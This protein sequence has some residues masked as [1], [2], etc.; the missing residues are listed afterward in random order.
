MLQFYEMYIDINSFIV[1]LSSSAPNLWE[2]WSALQAGNAYN[3]LMM[4]GPIKREHSWKEL[5]EMTRKHAEKTSPGIKFDENTITT[6][7][8]SA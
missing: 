8:F 1:R 6:N 5:E 2:V 4:E 3:K 7:I